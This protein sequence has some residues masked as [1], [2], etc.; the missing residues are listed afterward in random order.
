MSKIIDPNHEALCR[1]LQYLLRKAQNGAFH[2][3]ASDSATPKVDLIGALELLT[4]QAKEGAYDNGIGDKPVDNSQN[5]G[6][7]SGD[8]MGKVSG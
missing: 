8:S 3:F 2:D 4:A 6:D 5:D 7:K 1:D